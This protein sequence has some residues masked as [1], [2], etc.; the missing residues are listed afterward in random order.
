MIYLALWAGVFW[1]SAPLDQ[2]ATAVHKY[3]K[4]LLLPVIL[5]TVSDAIWRKRVLVAF[6]LS[7]V[8][9]LAASFGVYLGVPGL[10]VMTPGQGAIVMRS[11][12]AQSFL[13]ALLVLGASLVAVFSRDTWKRV[14]AGLIV[15]AALID[16][17]V[18]IQGRT[19]YVILLGL[20]AWVAWKLFSWRG[21]AAAL[22]AITVLAMGVYSL[23]PTVQMR[24]AAI[25]TDL[26]QYQAGDANTSAG[27]RLHFYARA[28]DIMADAPVFGAGTGAWKT[29][30]DKREKPTDLT[31]PQSGLGNPHN[32]FLLMGVQLG[33][34]GLLLYVFVLACAYRFAERLPPAYQWAAQ[35]V[36]VAYGVG[37]LF[38]SFMWDSTEGM[39]VVLLLAALFSAYPIKTNIKL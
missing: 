10:P 31:P 30:Y 33:S 24:V 37:A 11:H 14:L 27:L 36:L 39:V 7:C 1:S 16:M 26:Q 35:G 4:F 17:L 2:A 22:A 8:A 21:R 38:N 32:D 5:A 12:I 23:V 6:G 34:V 19:G 29:E 3:R 18:L 20:A 9:L 28:L 13:M 25:E 15:V